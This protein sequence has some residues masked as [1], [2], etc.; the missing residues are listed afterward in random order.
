MIFRKTRSSRIGLCLGGGGARGFAHIGALKALDEQGFKFDM[1]AGT[2]VGSLVGGL[3]AAGLSAAEIEQLGESINLKE[4]KSGLTPTDPLKIGAVVRSAVGNVR[5]E[6]LKTP[7]FAV[8]VD[9][10]EA[11][12]VVLDRGLLYEAVSASCAVPIFFRPLVKGNLHLVDG[13]LLNNIPADLL[14]MT[15]ADKVVTIDINP[16]RG[17]G[18][19]GLGLLDVAKATFSIMT[20]AASDTGLI[21]SDVIIAPDMSAF[22]ATSKEGH[23]EMISIGYNAASEKIE[24][25]RGLFGIKPNKKEKIKKRG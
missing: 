21:N 15:G 12:Q 8:A 20:A 2:S 13:G 4:I 25:I 6:D 3:Y 5:I 19:S 9:L 22:K 24:E 17:G 14:R 23:T 18:G 10:V 1:I 7:F 16:T 11:K